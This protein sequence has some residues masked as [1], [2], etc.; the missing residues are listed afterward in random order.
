MFHRGFCRS[1]KPKRMFNWCA[2]TGRAAR[3]LRTRGPP[4]GSSSHRIMSETKRR[5]AA[6]SGE[7]ITWNARANRDVE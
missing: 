6:A 2:A 5:D 4:E 3:T 7:A 1:V